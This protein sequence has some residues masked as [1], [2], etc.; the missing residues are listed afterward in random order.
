M[1][2]YSLPS[3]GLILLDIEKYNLILDKIINHQELDWAQ[4]NSLELKAIENDFYLESGNQ[5]D[6]SLVAHSP[7]PDLDII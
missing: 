6:I 2:L 4:F 7:I 3:G 5:F 1:N